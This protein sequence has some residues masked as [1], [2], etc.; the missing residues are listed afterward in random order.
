M[1][2]HNT[3]TTPPLITGPS[4][5]AGIAGW[6][7]G[8]LFNPWITGPHGMP[9][10]SIGKASV[11]ENYGII[12]NFNANEEVTWSVTTDEKDPVF[13][14]IS[15]NEFTRGQLQFD[16]APDYEKPDDL[17]K[18]NIYICTVRAT[19]NFGN[20][21]E[22]IVT[23]TVH[24]LDEGDS[25]LDIWLGENIINGS[26][27]FG[28]RLSFVASNDP[29]GNGTITQIN[30]GLAEG[31]SWEL[32]DDGFNWE[33]V[34]T[35]GFYV[36]QQKDE[37][38]KIRVVLSYEDGNGFSERVI[39]KEIDISLNNDGKASFEIT[40]SKVVGE[41]VK[42][43]ESVAD[44]DGEGTLSYKW[45]SS[46]DGI[47]WNQIG[48]SSTY[49]LTSNEEGKQIRNILSY[50][51]GQGF[52]E[53]VET[54]LVK[55]PLK[56]DGKGS[57]EITGNN[58]VSEIIKIKESAVDP[59]GEGIL[60]YKWQ[61]SSDGV[62]WNQI[63][64]NSTY[65]IT[66]NEE[67]KQIRN[68]LSYTDGQGF[69]EEVR[70]SAIGIP[71]YEIDTGLSSRGE[72]ETLTTSVKTKFVD[73]GTSLYWKLSGS[74]IN[75]NDFSS[76]SLSGSGLVGSDGTFSFSHL[77][78]ND[79]ATEGTE[80]LNIK[81]FSDSSYS[82]Q[83][84]ST[85]D[86]TIYDTS[87]KPTYK[88]TLNVNLNI[89]V[90]SNY[91]RIVDSINFKRLDI[92]PTIDLQPEGLDIGRTGINFA[93]ELNDSAI[94][95]V[96][97]TLTDLAPLL[98]GISATG[99]HLAYFGYIESKNE[100]EASIAT[101]LTYDPT[102]KAGARFYDLDKDGEADTTDLKLVDG[103]YGDKDGIKNGIIVDPS[104]AGVIDLNPEFSAR[105]SAL[106]VSDMSDVTSP[107]AL[108]VR[109]EISSRASSVNQIGYVA[110]NSNESEELTFKMIKDRGSILFSNLEET[111]APDLSLLTLKSDINIINGQKLVFFEVI[112]TTLET[113]LTRNTT[114]DGF[115]ES[116]RTLDLSN[117]SASE[118]LAS[119]G[120][121][122]ISLSLI[123][124][125]S[126]LDDLIS[127]EMD[128]NLILDFSGLSDRRLEGKVSL[129][130]EANFDSKVGFYRIQ[131]ANGAVLDPITGNLILPGTNNYQD[132]ALDEG[133][134]FKDFGNLSVENNTTKTLNISSFSNAGLLAPYV[135]IANTGETFFAYS[136]ANADGMSHFRSFGSG[137]IGIEDIKGGGDQDF[138]DLILGFNFNLDSV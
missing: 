56:N 9:G 5:N 29:D 83:V 135:N 101:T 71:S 94:N 35:D 120:G 57:F 79:F 88:T 108:L 77:I 32:S 59:D 128:E 69:S 45:Q 43:I 22:Q 41:T 133:N 116:F 62:T 104:T 86:L 36:I 130:R 7:N 10:S 12:Y 93:I 126:G 84:G 13:F 73:V 39:S 37:G 106:I 91:G 34:S 17:D 63:G 125:F 72:G 40:G 75:S 19:D 100:A 110:F 21:S 90:R 3:D 119:K 111:N 95:N 121:N 31:R 58:S 27:I 117:V 92:A 50:T 25:S 70:T 102:K 20:F 68:V 98:D 23:V 24:P 76:G 109:A 85:S 48:I 67:G 64:S 65:K 132:I 82:T 16:V 51:D 26:P 137:V 1:S 8:E 18:N 61:S 46:S 78:A 49:T 112:D 107:A 6:N 28:D 123:D 74:G 15:N 131:N 2:S 30:M 14:A 114:L 127:S 60:S 53:E 54:N 11:Y 105:T 81:L 66:S 38:K 44:P 89:F 118:A 96:A 80:N 122:V 33:E 4:G 115:G 134:L 55:I 124:S 103:G 52:I 87:V 99:K 129:F 136:A 97:K 138:D 42:I 47:N 113:L